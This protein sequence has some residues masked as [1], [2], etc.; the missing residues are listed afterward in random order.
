MMVLAGLS[1]GIASSLHCALMCGPLMG[2]APNGR[3]RP[4]SWRAAG[5]RLMSSLWHHGGRVTVYVLLGALMGST[6]L[7]LTTQ[8]L[9]SALAI[10]VGLAVI[11]AAVTRLRPR[12]RSGVADTWARL[13]GFWIG[14]LSARLPRQRRIRQI[15][16]GVLHGFLPCGLLYLALLAA[17]GL[18]SRTAAATF[19][20]GF[21]LGTI[22]ALVGVT[23]ILSVFRSAPAVMRRAT[24]IVT[25]IVGLLLVARGLGL[26]GP[27][28]H[29]AHPVAHAHAAER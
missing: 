17:T 10:V 14:R 24:P 15:S 16:L 1:L 26:A 9:R 6:E 20:L 7:V 2:L 23:S 8:G 18:G 5:T 28:A 13:I 3:G 25:I 22:P 4:L 27:A 29:H 21:G 19:M 11:V 12:W